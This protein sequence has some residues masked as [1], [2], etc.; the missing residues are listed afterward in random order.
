MYYGCGFAKSTKVTSTNDKKIQNENLDIIA[1]RRV[2]KM[3][4]PKIRLLFARLF[5]KI[6]NKISKIDLVD[7]ARNYRLIIR[8]VVDSIL[9]L[10]EYNRFQKAYFNGRVMI[11]KD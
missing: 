7:G 1:T 2:M 9:E 5:Y 10:K 11:Q 3:G 6:F 4:D 8:R